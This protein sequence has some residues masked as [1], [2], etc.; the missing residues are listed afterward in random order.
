[1]VTIEDLPSEPVI[2]RKENAPPEKVQRR[3]FTIDLDNP[4]PEKKPEVKSKLQRPLDEELDDT[5]ASKGYP[6]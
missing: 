1:M 2:L 5:E 6:R 3:K 4:E